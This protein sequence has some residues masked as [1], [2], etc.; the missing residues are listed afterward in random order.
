M[1]DLTITAGN[2]IEIAT[3]AIGGVIVVTTM[4]NSVA[5][6]GH[7]LT[8]MDADFSDMKIEIKKVGDVLIQMARTDVR[9][10]NVEQDMRGVV[11]DIREIKHGEGFIHKAIDREYP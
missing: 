3:I 11:Q 10:T 2:I 5:N 1:F 4:R 7:D 9:L 8:R 6:L